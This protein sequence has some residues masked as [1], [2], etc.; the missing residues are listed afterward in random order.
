MTLERAASAIG[1]LPHDEEVDDLNIEYPETDDMPMPDNDQQ[2][3]PV[4]DAL[5]ALRYHFSDRDD[6]YVSGNLF[7]Y[8]R[9]NDNRTRLAPD[10]FAV[11]GGTYK[12]M[13]DS[14]ITWREGKVPDFA[15]EMASR[16]T[17]R[18]DADEKRRIYAGMG[19]A[20]YWRFDPT[21][22][23]FRPP[24]VGERLEG[25]QYRPLPVVMDGGGIL[26]GHS[27]ILGLDICVL[28]GR[29]LRFY[30]PQNGQWL[31]SY[32]EEAEARQAAETALQQEIA[33]RQALE[34][35]IRRLR[36]QLPSGE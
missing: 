14:W 2:F 4:T 23:Y 12:G 27:A 20:E 10:V 17:W 3:I 32:E 5:S 7:V 33:A 30:D 29:L 19:V 22:R 34:E 13:R 15:M 21:G 1:K 36:Q 6:V 18:Y 11:V 31:R 24:L 9:M 28:P 8:Y 35:E 25:G 26:R 16:S